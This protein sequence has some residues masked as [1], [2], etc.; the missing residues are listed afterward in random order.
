MQ[1]QADLLRTEGER[2]FRESADHITRQT[3][4]LDTA[5]QGQLT[6]SLNSLG[7]QLASLSDK[8]VDDYTPLT[9]QL[10]RV[11]QIARRLEV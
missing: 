10:R 1:A 9:E 3:Q 7:S 8:F 5:L 6:Q 4:L 11:V 2:I